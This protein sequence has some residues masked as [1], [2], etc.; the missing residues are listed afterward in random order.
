MN[1]LLL[2]ALIEQIAIPEL[3]AWLASR[4]GSTLTDADIIQKLLT[5]TNLGEQIGEAWLAAHPQ[6][7]A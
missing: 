7:G 1:P 5:D 3:K 4:K 2:A 6:G